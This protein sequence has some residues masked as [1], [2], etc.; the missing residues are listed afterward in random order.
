MHINTYIV[1]VNFHCKMRTRVLLFT[2][3]VS[4]VCEVKKKKNNLVQFKIN[5]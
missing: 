2:M 5:N 4:F 1:S 3:I